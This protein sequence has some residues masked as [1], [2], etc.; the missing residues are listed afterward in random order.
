[1][2]KLYCEYPTIIGSYVSMIF[3]LCCLCECM[4]SLWLCAY[5]FSVLEQAR[6]LIVGA[7]GLGLWGTQLARKIYPANCN[8]TVADIT[9][10]SAKLFAALLTFLFCLKCIA[11]VVFVQVTSQKFNEFTS[12]DISFKLLIPGESLEYLCKL[13][14]R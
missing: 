13:P 10:S 14:Y 4:L 9:V 6:V 11:N 2:F 12:S 7:G 3:L 5:D 1:M 8:I